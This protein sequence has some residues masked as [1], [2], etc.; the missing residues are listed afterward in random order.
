MRALLIS[1]CLCCAVAL[2]AQ[3]NIAITSPTDNRDSLRNLS[4]RSFPD[5]FFIYPLIKQRSLNFELEKTDRSAL[6]TYKPNTSY[7]LGVGMYVFEVGVEL[8]FAVPL[9]E[10]SKSLYGDSD[11]RDIQ[12]NV[13]GKKWGV[14]AIYQ[15][16]SGFY[17][18][19]DD[20]S[21]PANTPYLQRRDI[22]SRNY[23]LTG[24]YI[25]N[26]RKFSFRSV[27]N[28]AERQLYSNGSFILSA[29]INRFKVSADSSIL[30]APQAVIFGDDVSFK[31]LSYS[32]FSIAPG[33]TYSLIFKNFF[34][35]GALSVGPAHHWIRYKLESG[36]DEHEIA[37]NAFVAARIGI[38]FNGDRLF[39]GITFI[40]QGSNVKF[41][42]VQFSN[43]NGVFKIA[44]GYRFRERGI[45]KR[46]A[47]DLLPFKV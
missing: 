45:L 24:H 44:M 14:D 17:I 40:T 42:D 19:E 3:E 29:S 20:D 28:F 37:I 9:D 2:Q 36:V 8:A 16:Y 21:P 25:F 38:G 18:T 23:G 43:N 34:L 39:G 13:L 11:A 1:I 35:N 12:L 6:L 47:W 41:E 46:R 10:K 32:T 4:I 31:K 33:Y 30:T 5:H 22:E 7:S 15:K 27:Y 26:N